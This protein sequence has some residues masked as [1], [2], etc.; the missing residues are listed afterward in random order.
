VGFR[1]LSKIGRD[2]CRFLLLR[3]DV[4][5]LMLV[6][7]PDKLFGTAAML[8]PCR[9]SVNNLTDTPLRRSEA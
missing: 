7:L 2:C 8:S 3:V 6:S 9:V 4:L 1:M 5:L